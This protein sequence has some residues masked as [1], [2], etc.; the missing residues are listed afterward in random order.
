MNPSERRLAIL[1]EDH[2]LEY[3]HFEGKIPKGEYGAGEVR[4]LDEGTFEIYDGSFE[5]SKLS[6]NMR[7]KVLKG[8]FSLFALKGNPKNWLLIKKG[9]NFADD[10]FFLTPVIQES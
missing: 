3:A 9:D 8:L 6:I 2:P 7:G 1:V 4:I 5:K 10:K